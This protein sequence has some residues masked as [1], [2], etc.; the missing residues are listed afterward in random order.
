MRN[1]KLVHILAC[2]L[3]YNFR[4]LMFLDYQYPVLKIN[5]LQNLA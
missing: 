3:M 1:P 2:I 5:A 4:N